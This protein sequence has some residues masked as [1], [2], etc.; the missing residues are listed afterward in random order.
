MDFI[1][2]Y[3]KKHDYQPVTMS[4]ELITEQTGY[5]TTK[6]IVEGMVLAGQR[7]SDYRHGMLDNMS[8]DYDE[9][10]DAIETYMDD[11]V[12]L[13]NAVETRVMRYRAEKEEVTE[14]EES[15][16]EEKPEVQAPEKKEPE[17]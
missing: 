17:K 3:G 10:Q 2:N 14:K 8:E 12:D 1:T 6:E 9:E 16:K 13:Q 7:L 11:P 5:R 4:Q 15:P